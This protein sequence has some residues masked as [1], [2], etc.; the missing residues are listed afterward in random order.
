LPTYRRAIEQTRIDLAAAQLRGI[1]AAQRVYYL[2][3][4]S[5]TNDL[6]VLGSSGLIDTTSLAVDTYYYY[7]LSSTG[8]SFAA[9]ASR[10]GSTSYTG[11]ISIN[12]TGVV[13]GNVSG[14]DGS[15]LTPGFQ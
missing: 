11:T 2:E 13:T 5:Y 9:T 4:R 14:A 3:N 12:E 8:S 7:S 6:T 10:S 15:T 1:W